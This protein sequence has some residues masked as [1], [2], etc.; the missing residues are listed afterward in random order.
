MTTN[1]CTDKLT[2]LEYLEHMIPHHQVAVDMCDLLIPNTCDPQMLLL[3]RNI[4]KIQE[5]EIW[6]MNNM[7][8]LYVTNDNIKGKYNSNNKT[9]MDI[10][11]PILSTDKSGDCNPLFFKPDDHSNH[12]KHMKINRKSFLEHMI[13][14]HQVAIDMSKR[15]LLHSSNSY[16][17]EFCIQLIIEQQGEIYYMNNLLNNNNIIYD[18][19]LMCS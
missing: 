11:Y 1:P 19:E 7:K 12:M 6:E 9:I 3:C 16:L 2:D 18:S 10:Y 5:Y 15:L 8:K 13:P 4:K 17:I 14:H